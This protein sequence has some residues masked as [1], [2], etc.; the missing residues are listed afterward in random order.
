MQKER[1]EWSWASEVMDGLD[2]TRESDGM[3]VKRLK[4]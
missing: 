4:P 1:K 2:R 3:E